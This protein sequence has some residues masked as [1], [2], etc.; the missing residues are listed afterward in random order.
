MTFFSNW[1][2]IPGTFNAFNVGQPCVREMIKKFLTPCTSGYQGVKIWPLLFNIITLQ[3]N[4][5]SPSLFE[6]SYPF[7]IEG[8]FLVPKYSFTDS[9][10]PSLLP[11]CV[12]RRWEHIE[13][14][15]NHIKRI[16]GIEEGFQIHI[17]SQ[18]SWQLVM[19]GQGH[20]PARIEHRE[21]VFLANFLWFPGVAASICLHNMHRL[22]CD[23]A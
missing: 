9:M 2:N 8:L 20:C 17:Q 19:C 7:K 14:R 3:D 6:L 21:S 22:S 23:L 15:R 11:Y 4:A 13:A 10:T 18:Q 12:P 1:Q 5:L 16:W